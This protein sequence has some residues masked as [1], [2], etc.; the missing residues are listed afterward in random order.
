MKIK[1]INS[2]NNNPKPTFDV[3]V[4]YNSS[5]RYEVEQFL[6]RLKEKNKRLKIWYDR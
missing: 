6:R 1:L 5:E 3:F 2:D 4:S